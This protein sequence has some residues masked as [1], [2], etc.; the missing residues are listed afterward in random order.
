MLE[1]RSL[2]RTRPRHW[3]RLKKS[4]GAPRY[5]QYWFCGHRSNGFSSHRLDLTDEL[6][7]Q[8]FLNLINE[9]LNALAPKMM[10]YFHQISVAIK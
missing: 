7:E 5:D 1:L 2:A 6:A 9:S 8:Y 10:E 3:R 4:F